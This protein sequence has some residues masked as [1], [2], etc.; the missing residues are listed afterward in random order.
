M[1]SVCCGVSSVHVHYVCVCVQYQSSI[2]Y[3]W[4]MFEPSPLPYRTAA[5]SFKP[6]RAKRQHPHSWRYSV[7]PWPYTD[8]CL[9]FTT[10]NRH[11]R[12]DTVW[13]RADEVSKPEEDEKELFLKCWIQQWRTE[14]WG[15]ERIK[16]LQGRTAT[17]VH[18]YSSKLTC[19]VKKIWFEG[20]TKKLHMI[21]S[22]RGDICWNITPFVP[23]SRHL[24][25]WSHS[26]PVS[27]TTF[28]KGLV[29]PFHIQIL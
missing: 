18:H 5:R 4:S 14:E 28:K 15:N 7:A 25:L 6:T 23:G 1:K 16:V 29:L 9:S 2:K 20:L 3:V 8:E 22:V 13:M 11:K 26:G 24:G 27:T 17:L 10:Q 12:S 21:E 19:K